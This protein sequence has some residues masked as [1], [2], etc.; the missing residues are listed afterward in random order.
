MKEDKVYSQYFPESRS[1]LC[2]PILD[3]KK[4]IGAIN[5]QDNKKNAFTDEDRYL[6]E[7]V[8]NYAASIRSELK[9][10]EN[11]NER[12]KELRTLYELA[13]LLISTI[14]LE[15]LLN[16]I[17]E[18]MSTAF[19]YKYCAILIQDHAQNALCPVATKG[20]PDE[21][22]NMKIPMGKG[23]TG[24]AA[25]TGEV[26]FV[27]DVTQHNNYIKGSPEIISEIAAPL[28][29][30]NKLIGILDVASDR[31]IFTE[32]D[33]SFLSAIAT[34]IAF[35][36]ENAQLYTRLEESHESLQKNFFSTIQALSAAIEAKDPSTQG[37]VFRTYELSIKV[38]NKL[39]LSEKEVE[40][41]KYA[42]LL[43]DI[44]KIGI[45]DAILL[46]P[47]ELDEEEWAVIK[48]HPLIGANIV[49]QIDFLKVPA[50]I[51]LYH[52]ERYDGRTYGKFSGY[53]YGL[54]GEQI[55]I[56]S[57][58]ISVVDSFDAMVS[59][60]PYRDAL[61]IEHAVDTLIKERGKQFDPTV[62][63][64]FLQVLNEDGILQENKK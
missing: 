4:V 14:N 37:H 13:T 62:V 45:P 47:S 19:N 49:Q 18:Y 38:A 54:H 1:E 27:A 33:I 52:Q 12:A 28:K 64:K 32:N 41:I 35:A 31:V 25:Q 42:S 21:I 7:S 44:G 24:K 6:M 50:E 39:G 26:E 8:A 11:V 34:E 15:D 53:P 55:P 57:R 48:K 9:L 5:L 51:I 40:Y 36:I 60:R 30:G 23:I 3:H 16:K 29:A 61:P 2:V 56:G 46:K 43:H 63:D 58:I 59:K 20:Y 10:R 22:K 17:V